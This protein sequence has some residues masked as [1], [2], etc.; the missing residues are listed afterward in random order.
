MDTEICIASKDVLTYFSDN[1]DYSSLLGDFINSIKS[2]EI[3]DDKIM[4]YEIRGS[5]YYA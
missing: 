3:I 5:Y 1:F 2:S 4:A